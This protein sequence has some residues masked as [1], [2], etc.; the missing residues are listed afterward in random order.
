MYERTIE[1]ESAEYK[2]LSYTEPK[3]N[4]DR[5]KVPAAK[6]AKLVPLPNY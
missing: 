6:A 2:N 3:D 1:A 4:F 5:S